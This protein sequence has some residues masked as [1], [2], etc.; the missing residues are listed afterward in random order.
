MKKEFGDRMS[1]HGAMDVQKVLN[2]DEATVRADV[3]TR[4]QAL[5]P[6]GGFILAPCNHIQHDIPP[7]NVV[8][9]YAEAR[10]FGRY[11]LSV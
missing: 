3:R 9:M 6:G 2:Q 7:E 10:E 4:I 1:F 11:P 8:A 5:G